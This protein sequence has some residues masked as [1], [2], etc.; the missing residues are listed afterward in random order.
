MSSLTLSPAQSQI[1][2]NKIKATNSVLL[3]THWMCTHFKYGLYQSFILM[4]N[5]KKN[6]L[7][8]CWLSMLQPKDIGKIQIAL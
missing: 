4:V 3:L 6:G 2:G 5:N 8:V 1:H 7:S